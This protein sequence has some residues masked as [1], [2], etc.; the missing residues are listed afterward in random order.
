MNFKEIL[1]KILEYESETY[2]A[3]G[4]K[5][6]DDLFFEVFDNIDKTEEKFGR[7]SKELLDV[8]KYYLKKIEEMRPKYLSKLKNVK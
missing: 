7:N 3:S 4:I 8:A 6:Y 1:K 2:G 5:A